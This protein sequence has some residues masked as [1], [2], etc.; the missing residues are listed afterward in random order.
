LSFLAIPAAYTFTRFFSLSPTVAAANNRVWNT[1]VYVC[2][3]ATSALLVS[4]AAVLLF[5]FLFRRTENLGAS[6]VGS[7]SFGLG[8][9]MLGW[10]T[11]FFSHAAAGALLMMGL[12]AL[13]HAARQINERRAFVPATLSGIAFG[14]ATSVEYTSLI[15]ALIIG[16]CIGLTT[17]WRTRPNEVILMFGAVGLGAILPLVP[18]FA[19]HAAAFGS[20]F[21]TGYENAVVFQATRAGFFGIGIPNLEVIG[22]LLFGTRRGIFWTSP[23]MLPALWATIVSM[24]RR[25]TRILA[26]TSALILVWYVLMNSGFSYWLGGASTGPRYLTPAL[27]IMMLPLGL[28]WPHFGIHEKYITLVIL[29]ASVLINLAAA[30]V[31][32]AAPEELANPLTQWIWPN[33]VDGQLIRTAVFKFTQTPGLFNLMPLL[34]LWAILAGLIYREARKMSAVTTLDVAPV[35]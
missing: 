20:P 13:D 7:I 17:D 24:R 8:T 16:M 30:A 29:A 35:C 23:V 5:R 10:A 32:M 15:P 3:H 19:Y 14:T 18:V 9:P 11:S 1:F 12:I 26:N 4:L 2:A 33:L 27:G 34:I 31:T 28:A 21:A 6:L 22:E 25:E